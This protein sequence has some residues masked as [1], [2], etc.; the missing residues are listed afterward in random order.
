MLTSVTG[1]AQLT[2]S[3]ASATFTA[4]PLGGITG[5]HM[6][7]GQGV[8]IAGATGGTCKLVFNTRLTG[9]GVSVISG[10]CIR[11]MLMN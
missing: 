1:A 5:N 4:Q 10:S 9:S 8:L 11:V 7:A 2:A 3:D 6:Y